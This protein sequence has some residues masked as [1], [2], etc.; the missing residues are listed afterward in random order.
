MLAM[1]TFKNGLLVARAA[2]SFIDLVRHPEHLDRVFEISDSLVGQRR[3]VLVL[4]RDHI[5]KDPRGEAS[6]RER[7]RLAVRLDELEK[8][9]AGSFGRA[10]ADHM[11]KNGLDPAAIP[12]LPARE[13]LEYVR[14]H[15]YETHDVWHALTGFDTDV[16]GEL[17]LQ[18]FYA[19]Q[20][21]G[22]L[23]F[24]LLAVGF[25]NTAFFSMADRERRFDAVVRGWQMGRS[26]KPV[27]GV[28]WGD[29]WSRPVG[30]VRQ[31]L[32]VDAT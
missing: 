16:A 4:M 12:T 1:N 23:P 14:A 15:L 19:A 3:D 27:F 32:G 10:F 26:A 8:L 25:L 22:G 18:S 5:A 20:L 13:D 21:P 29:L 2:W 6:L 31:L 11:R 28:A 30:E 24:L 9:P 7:P 17:G